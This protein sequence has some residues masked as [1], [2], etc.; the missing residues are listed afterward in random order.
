MGLILKVQ[1]T[2]RR[3]SSPAAPLNARQI[4]ARLHCVKARGLQQ[5]PYTCCL[6]VS[7]FQ[8]QP[9][10]RMQVGRSL[11]NDGS[12]VVQTIGAAGQRLERFM[13]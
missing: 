1:F 7:M 2:H 5:F 4:A 11:R 3:Q 12:G 13:G 10:A 9:P 8:Q 6:V